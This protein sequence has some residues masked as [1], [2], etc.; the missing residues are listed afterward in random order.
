MSRHGYNDPDYMAGQAGNMH[1]PNGNR[2]AFEA[3]QQ[4]RQSQQQ[5][6]S[7]PYT[8]IDPFASSTSTGTSN[9]GGHIS[10][11][12]ALIAIA[13]VCSPLIYFGYNGATGLFK[14]GSDVIKKYMQEKKRAKAEPYRLAIEETLKTV[15]NNPDMSADL[16]ILAAYG[17]QCQPANIKAFFAGNGAVYLDLCGEGKLGTLEA[18]SMRA[19]DSLPIPNKG[20]EYRITYEV[21]ALPL[22]SIDKVSTPNNTEIINSAKKQFGLASLQKY[23]KHGNCVIIHGHRGALYKPTET[24]LRT[25]IATGQ[26]IGIACLSDKGKLI[27]Q[28][29]V[30]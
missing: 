28:K 6:G 17:V 8:F 25:A 11:K 16:K 14:N 21:T 30:N 23:Q 13:I 20:P 15:A 1:A 3:G 27:L 2:D 5:S 22:A 10:F 12:E 24:F 7:D 26:A 29:K 19:L 4:W 9:V 18:G